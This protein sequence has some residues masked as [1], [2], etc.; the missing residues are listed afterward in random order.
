MGVLIILDIVPR[1]VDPDAWAGV[2]D[3]LGRLWAASDVE[4]A[5]AENA[6]ISRD[7]GAYVARSPS[8]AEPSDDILLAAAGVASK[9]AP[10]L[11]P[12]PK[13][14]RSSPPVHARDGI[15]RALGDAPC[16]TAS[17]TPLLAGAM[18]VEARMPRRAMVHGDVDR[19]RAE[20]AR[21]WAEGVLG[22][23]RPIALPVRV[24]AWRLAER[25]G[26]DLSGAEL[27]RAVDRLHLAAPA[28]K[29]AA[30]LAIFGH[31][32]VD[33]CWLD[34]LRVAGHARA[35]RAVEETRALVASYVEATRDLARV[36]GFACLDARGPRWP[37]DAFVE[38]L[39]SSSMPVDVIAVERA[40]G[41]V[42]GPG[43]ERLASI[44]RDRV[45]ERA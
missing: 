8:D 30:L 14:A 31:A 29:D 6:G 39:A 24:D 37:P 23:D 25:L 36:L 26:A 3:E 18:L 27:E 32:L 13:T 44:Y 22:P 34:K 41:V 2:C 35:D 21:R 5:H 28:K 40:L 20:A 19:E 17:S 12:V 42:F 1:R 9:R 4:A 38:I 10:P 11:Y 33:P 15:V 16:G 45:R 7:I 43:A